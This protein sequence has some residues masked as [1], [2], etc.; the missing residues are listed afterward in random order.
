MAKFVLNTTRP[1]LGAEK[2]A[3]NIPLYGIKKILFHLGTEGSKQRVG[4]NQC[5]HQFPE[6]TT[7]DSNM[8]QY[9]IIKGL[10]STSYCTKYNFP[11]LHRT[12]SGTTEVQEV[13]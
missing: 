1:V 9:Q 6:L 4:G 8:L 11:P 5:W 12:G 3:E 2:V 7:L 10:C 13:F